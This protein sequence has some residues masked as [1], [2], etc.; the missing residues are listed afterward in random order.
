MGTPGAA[1]IPS[2]IDDI[3]AS[4]LSAA[5]GLEVRSVEPQLIGVGIGVTS[6]VYRLGLAG[7]PACPESV[8]V[9]LPALD[10]AAVFTAQ[11][12]RMYI[13][14]VAFF[15]EL[16]PRSPVRVP[17]S[18]FGAVD[19]DTSDFVM[20]LEDVGGMR[21]VDQLEGMALP[22]AEH[23][24][25]ELAAW[26]ATWWRQA[27]E[28]AERGITVRL[29]DPLYPAILPMVFAEGWEKVTGALDVAPSI[30]EVG[31]QFSDAL[32]HLLARLDEAP[33]TLI[34]GDYRADNMLFDDDGSLVLLDFQLIGTGSGA[35]DLAYFLT[36]SLGPDD[37]ADHE[38]ALF[39]RW[40]E[41]L[42]AAGV[43]AGDLD[44]AWEDYRTA[45]LFCLV[46]PIVA[47]RGMDLSDPRQY[48]LIDCMNTRFARAVDQLQ[49]AELLSA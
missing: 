34:H 31:P 39:E 36:Q 4:W 16:A 26:H 14:E 7:G 47:S 10:P 6:A 40:S 11:V 27:D 20:V 42:R 25:D 3:T 22:D 12:L 44:R 49:L 15:R 46:Y 28:L 21:V 24:V 30:L 33:T 32:P 5:I 37:A 8:V 17:G 13:R 45:A 18:F 1:A 29:G 9:K 23:A 19:E 2:G 48:E 43:P 41:G 35:Y 38:R